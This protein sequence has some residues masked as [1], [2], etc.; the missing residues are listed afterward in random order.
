MTYGAPVSMTSAF[1]PL[2]LRSSG[3]SAPQKVAEILIFGAGSI[4]IFKLPLEMEDRKRV[5][6]KCLKTLAALIAFV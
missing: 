2:S 3:S 6:S 1:L 5:P 4:K